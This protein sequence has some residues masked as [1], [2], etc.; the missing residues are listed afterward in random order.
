MKT[1]NILLGVCFTAYLILYYQQTPGLNHLLFS[2][3]LVIA[4]L[5]SDASFIRNK[6]WILVAVGAVISGLGVA[7]YGN[8][9]SYIAN[10][11]AIASLAGLSY[12]PDSSLIF[13]SLQGAFS[14]VSS[15]IQ[16]FITITNK[17][18]ADKAN[19][20]AKKE[21]IWTGSN[22]LK[23]FIP[24]LIV[25]G[26]AVV[27]SGSN[28]VF[29]KFLSELG[30]YISWEFISFSFFGFYV[31]YFF[32]HQFV[33]PEV[34]SFDAKA[35]NILLAA[36][37][38]EPTIF[39]TILNEHGA[40]KLTFILLNSLLLLVNYL[41]IAF[42]IQPD[43]EILDYSHYI[44]QGINAS[45]FSVLLAILV[46]LYFFRGN[47]NFIAENRSLKSLA[48]VWLMLNVI[49]LMTCFHK[50]FG[51]IDAYGLTP[52]RIGVYAYL[53]VTFIG[54]MLTWYK[55][56]KRKSN[57]FLVRSNFWSLF[58]LLAVSTS[59]HWNQLIFDHNVTYHPELNDK[60]YY[61]ISPESSLAHLVKTWESAQLD[62]SYEFSDCQ[63]QQKIINRKEIFIEA[64]EAKSWQSWTLKD[65]RIYKA[66]KN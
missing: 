44:H 40:A 17:L 21:L 11:I 16:K 45:I 28:P 4:L 13:A 31:V 32:F 33:F 6:P 41:D 30:A 8:D 49:L 54:L 15:P 19:E 2:V 47:L 14:Y 10:L 9:L 48:I 37:P 50:N 51:Y 66:L 57:M 60:Y 38:N 39:G 55:I 42:I 61:H 34:I 24:V 65:Y 22:V 53:L 64:F 43:K 12:S 62:C 46:V 56:A 7:L 58:L 52:K 27:Y 5:F 18:S 25:L 23:I 63:F 26:F 20:D 3:I 1:K 35:G 36:N 29:S 59:V